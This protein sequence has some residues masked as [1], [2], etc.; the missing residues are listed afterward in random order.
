MIRGSPRDSAAYGPSSV[1][2]LGKYFPPFDGGMENFL[3]D[4]LEA[5]VRSGTKVAAI[6]HNHHGLL[7]G[8]T[9]FLTGTLTGEDLSGDRPVSLY[10]VPALGRVL[11]APVSPT[12]PFWLRR[13]IEAERPDILHLHL[14][15]T[16]A[17]WALLLPRARAV[18][19][20][21]HW[22]ADVISSAHS[23]G[24]RLAYPLYRPLEQW[25]LRRASMIV[26]TS[27]NYLDSSSALAPWH[28]KCRVVPLGIDRQRIPR[29]SDAMRR[30]A[31][32]LWN[33]AAL[34]ILTVGRL[35]YYKGNEYLIE[36]VKSV[37]GARLLIVG[38]G[39][40]RAKLSALTA[41]LGIADRVVLMGSLPNEDMHALMAT[42]DCFCLASM[43]RTEAFGVVLLE[44][45]AHGKAVVA[46]D[47][48]GSG[49]GWVVQDGK[50]GYVVS[51]ADPSA[52]A[53]AFASLL[54]S[55]EEL[56]RLGREGVRRYRELFDIERV[57]GKMQGV[58]E[59]VLAGR[60]HGE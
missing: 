28:H 54:G 3:A 32:G 46:C 9:S 43:E 21:V 5:Q 13:A 8:E 38:E 56:V 41:E 55:R 11:Y 42:C 36:A 31:E 27:Q 37:P 2:H 6:V 33:H 45:M 50:T 58:Y 57:T 51:P 39:E 4:L 47:I 48:A 20:V 14:P 25:L 59:E 34:R 30:Q 35:T 16:S 26:A 15:N 29:T 10:R 12:F 1:L 53:R 60:T 19:W 40:R 23:L 17:F 22:H 49:V 24:L 52:L 44:A 7:R 18:P